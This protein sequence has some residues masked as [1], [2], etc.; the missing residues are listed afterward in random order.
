[1]GTNEINSNKLNEALAKFGSLQK[2]N[3]QLE[4]DKLVL[5]KNNSQLKQEN[6]QLSRSRRVLARNI[7]AMIDKRDSYQDQLNELSNQIRSHSF[8]HEVLCGFMAMAAESPSITDSIDNLIASFQRLKEPGWHLSKN[9]EE[10]RTL[11]VRMVMGD[12]LKCFRCKVCGAQFMVNKAPHYQ[13]LGKNYYYYC[14]SCYSNNGVEPDDSFLKAIVSEKQVEN[15]KYTEQLVNENE[16][17]KPFKAYF[18]VPCEICHEPVKEWDDFNVKFAMRG[19]GFGHTQCWNNKSGQLLQ[20]AK[21]VEI[22][23]KK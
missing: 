14:P 6:E 8:Q 20:L 22:L 3:A 7:D 9:A 15:T 2:A 12:F 11:F 18:S 13:I 21:A 19:I 16:M 4:S 5:E 17:L 1:M 10:M 23:S